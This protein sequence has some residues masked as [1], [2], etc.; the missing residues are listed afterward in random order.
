[1]AILEALPENSFVNSPSDGLSLYDILTISSCGINQSSSTGL[2]FMVFGVPVIQY[3]PPRMGLY[4]PSFSRCV[5]REDID[6]FATAVQSAVADADGLEIS[7]RAFRWLGISLLR[8]LLHLRPIEDLA[9]VTEPMTGSV[10]TP[11]AP[12]RTRVS[13]AAWRRVIPARARERAARYLDRRGRIQTMPDST[14]REFWTQEL[15]DR[16]DSTIGGPIWMPLVIPRGRGTPET[17]M[18][19]VQRELAALRSY[20]GLDASSA[21][22]G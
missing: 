16:L 21:G 18:V 6:A 11:P 8:V 5:D 19:E 22:Q 2:E 15:L 4:P 9:P 12:P 1:M 14:S 7:R 10:L 20:L 13:P 17:E 3:D